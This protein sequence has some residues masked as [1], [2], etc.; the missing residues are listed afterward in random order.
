MNQCPKFYRDLD[1]FIDL[2]F[3]VLSIKN[4]DQLVQTSSVVNFSTNIFNLQKEGTFLYHKWV[5][6]QFI[7]PFDHWIFETNIYV[8]WNIRNGQFTTIKKST[9]ELILLGMVCQFI[10]DT[11]LQTPCS[12]QVQKIDFKNKEQVGWGFRA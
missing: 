8:C 11:G 9:F 1:S 3:W 2:K 5:V 12:G 4:F 10:L 6:H 7:I